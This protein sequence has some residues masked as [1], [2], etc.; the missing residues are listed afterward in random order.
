MWSANTEKK[1][2]VFKKLQEEHMK[3]ILDE[4]IGLKVLGKIN[5]DAKG[6]PIK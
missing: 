4:Q 1:R 3:T 5:L 6:N 2:E